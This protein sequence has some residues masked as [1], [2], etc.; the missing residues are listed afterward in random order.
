MKKLAIIMSILSVVL[1]AV[2]GY[3]IVML[4]S[5]LTP[6]KMG[7]DGFGHFIKQP[8]DSDFLKVS[9]SVYTFQFTHY[10]N[11]IV[12]TANGL[13]LID[14][15]NYSLS[16]SD[17]KATL[18]REFPGQP[19][20]TIIY[21]HFHKDHTS[22]SGIFGAKR[23]IAHEDVPR[24]LAD[25]P[26]HNVELPTELLMSKDTV[27]MIDGMKTEFLYL[28]EG[29]TTTNFAIH[30]PSERTMYVADLAAVNA[31]PFILMDMYIPAVIRNLEK[32][33][34]VDFDNLVTCHFLPG[35]KKDVTFSIQFMKDVRA[36]TQEAFRKHGPLN[37]TSG[38]KI[39]VQMYEDMKA[40]YGNLHGY[41]DLYVL[42]ITRA[43]L[44]ELVGY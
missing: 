5:P 20:H 33:E 6:L 27:M 39:Q 26:G 9:D 43:F 2:L 7:S 35:K 29:H 16:A 37:E 25:Y 17:L 36:I 32:V 30:F 4:R 24:Y 38:Y 21:S 28:A 10:T 31:M 42:F 34:L 1:I 13:M 22:G 12:R 8:R 14:P 23:I 41:D 15:S 18:E 3:I 44:G 19:V 40:K 11:M